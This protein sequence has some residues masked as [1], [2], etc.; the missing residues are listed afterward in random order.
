MT[1]TLHPF[2]FGHNVKLEIQLFL[3]RLFVLIVSREKVKLN[4]AKIKGSN[5][6]FL[7]GCFS[8]QDVVVSSLSLLVKDASY[9][10]RIILHGIQISQNTKVSRSEEPPK[11]TKTLT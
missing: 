6:R 3:A 9:S 5:V 7:V 11:T 8:C 2:S 4:L 1:F 10:F